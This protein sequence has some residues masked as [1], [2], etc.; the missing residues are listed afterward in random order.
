MSASLVSW[1]SVM[2]RAPRASA[3]GTPIASST[4]ESSGTP[5]WHAEPVDTAIPDASSR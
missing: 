4:C 5:A 1:P 3:S 2:R